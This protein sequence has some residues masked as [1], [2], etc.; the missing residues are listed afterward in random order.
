[1]PAAHPDDAE[2]LSFI[3]ANVRY[4]RDKRGLT[5]EALAEAAEMDLR[6][7]SRIETA[8]AGNFAVTLFLRLAKVL[9]VREAEL[10]KPR[11]L[12]KPTRGR[13]VRVATKKRASSR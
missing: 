6:Q 12:P 9:A 11:E 7:L 2:T 4:I 10:L 8:R 3:A 1:M 5:Q 13:P